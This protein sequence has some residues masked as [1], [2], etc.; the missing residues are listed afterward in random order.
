[1][2]ASGQVYLK[3]DALHKNGS[4]IKKSNDGGDENYLKK[5]CRS[6]KPLKETGM[7]K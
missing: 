4:S 1:M 3:G 7:Q 5:P 6:K 2:T